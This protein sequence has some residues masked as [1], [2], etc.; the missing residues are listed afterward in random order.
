[1][2]ILEKRILIDGKPLTNEVI[3]VGSFLNHRLD[4]RLL[5]HIG[6]EFRKRFDD[7]ADRVNMILTV[8]SS[9]IAIAAFTAKCFGYVPVLIAKKENPNAIR[10]GYYFTD[11]TNI[12][13]STLTAI[14]VEKKYLGPDDHCLIIDDKLARGEDVLGLVHISKEA[15]AEILGAGVVIE[16][17]FQNGG[18]KLRERG[19]RVE[20]LA[21]VTKLEDGHIYLKK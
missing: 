18:K 12:G 14:R 8:E 21:V 10:E 4:I 7:V 13:D 11:V 6:E 17:E 16:K 20:P 9:G 5:E 3:D 19:I 1:M 15:G 2:E